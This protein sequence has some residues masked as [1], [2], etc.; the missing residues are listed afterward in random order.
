MALS[1]ATK[2]IIFAHVAKHGCVFCNALYEETGCTAKGQRTM[3]MRFAS[4]VQQG[5]IKAIENM[6]K[7]FPNPAKFR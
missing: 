5:S 1:K 7:V 4:K 2:E 6:S 3:V